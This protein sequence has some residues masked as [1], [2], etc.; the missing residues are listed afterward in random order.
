M[1]RAT[2]RDY[3]DCGMTGGATSADQGRLA[4]FIGGDAAVLDRARPVL[5]A[6]TVKLMHL[7]PAG[8]G[9]AMKLVHNMITHTTFLATV[10]GC[11]ILEDAGLDLAAVVDALNSGNARSYASEFRFPKHILSGTWD[12]RSYVSNLAKDLGMAVKFGH[13]AGH[14]T[15]FGSLTSTILDRAIE[16]G[17]AKDDYALLYK[18]FDGLVAS[19]EEPIEV[20]GK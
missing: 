8:A 13:A 2:G 15:V 19:F 9:H 7:G 20:G 4:L 18:Y 12:A 10:E 5:E 14:A 16:Q 3:L 6:F 17:K 11:R 1:A